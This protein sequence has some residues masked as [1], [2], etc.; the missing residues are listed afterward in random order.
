MAP[1]AI[2]PAENK[3]ETAKTS[4]F[5]RFMR[6]FIGRAVVKFGLVF[7]VIFILTAIFAPLL[8]PYDPNEQ[9]ILNA[10]QQPSWEHLLGTDSLGRDTLSRVIYGSQ[11][12]LMVGLI[13]VSVSAIIGM[14]L[15]LL[16]GYFGGW[17]Y[18]II[19]RLVDAF[20]AF[21]MLVLTLLIAAMLGQGIT[22][23]IIALSVG[24][25]PI[26]ARLMCG[27][28]I[29]VKNNDYIT[30]GRSIGAGDMRM[31]LKHIFPNC[32]PPLI[33]MITMMLGSTILAEASLSFL[34]VGIA[35]P[36][37]AWG[38]MVNDGRT[39]LLDLPVLSFAP[40]LAIMLVVFSFNMV[41]D[42]LRDALDPRLRGV[43]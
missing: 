35:P 31:M 7:I 39:Y 41:G 18:T 3:A 21:P 30:A 6:V 33:V 5:R 37:P 8:A 27:Q 13:V 42:G 1:E 29:S 15:G 28:A 34:G 16:A 2:L 26:Y 43:I 32:L 10:L 9:D 40:G 17:T 19:M 25:I 12:S 24:L 22:N 14:A 36:T 4:G 23:V 38:G 11:T 20:M